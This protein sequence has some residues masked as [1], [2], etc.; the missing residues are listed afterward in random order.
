MEP[1]P[2]QEPIEITVDVMNERLRVEPTQNFI[3]EKKRHLERQGEERRLGREIL[4]EERQEKARFSLNQEAE[5]MHE[6]ELKHQLEQK[7]QEENIRKLETASPEA[8][9]ELRELIRRRY[10][11]DCEIW[12]LRHR[13]KPYRPIVERKMVQA[14]EVLK[15]ITSIVDAWGDNRDHSWTEEEWERVTEIRRRLA[16]DGKRV[17][18]S[19]PPWRLEPTPRQ[20]TLISKPAVKRSTSISK[21]IL[22]RAK[23]I[24]LPERKAR[25]SK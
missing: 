5:K 24:T 12:N 2:S 23:L 3:E 8:L 7:R 4:D 6:A 17:W 10:A 15:E 14:D 21:P 22:G 25:N 13:T 1:N 19:D 16:K 18:I 11:L 9:R 20:P